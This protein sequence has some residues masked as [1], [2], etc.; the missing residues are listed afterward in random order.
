MTILFSFLPIYLINV[1]ALD[2]VTAGSI[3]GLIF[4]PWYLK[5]VYGGISDRLPIGRFGRRRPYI[6]F[7]V[8]LGLLGW[9]F[10]PLI[11]NINIIF[12]SVGLLT[13][14]STACADANID[15]L[16]IDV[17]PINERGFLQGMMWGCRGLGASFSGYVSGVIIANYGWHMLF[18]MAGILSV[19][20]ILSTFF[21]LEPSGSPI[22]HSLSSLKGLIKQ[23]NLWLG[24]I[25]FPLVNIGTGLCFVF[26]SPF[27]VNE[28]MLPIDRVGLC[29][30]LF[31][32][33]SIFSPFIAGKMSDSIGSLK[34]TCIFSVLW[35]V[36]MVLMLTIRPG[37]I[38]W[39]TV[40]SL[41]VGGAWGA[42]ITILLRIAMDISHPEF[43]G[44]MFA[45]FTSLMNFGALWIGASLGGLII[46]SWGYYA[47]FLV[48][49]VFPLAALIFMYLMKS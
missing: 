39:P 5:F 15:G 20:M 13:V 24:V 9:Y 4:L 40:Y 41:L 44:L 45:V 42:L 47:L 27:L 38:L 16:A 36:A 11:S 6:F 43:A 46:I 37:A 17:T 25:Y 1:F 19:V 8:C 14:F 12:I 10:A 49:G 22:K 34:T 31:Y 18:W 32:A 29:I 30:S 3:Y 35:A 33:G 26:F 23:K 28:I 7:S 2:P 21:I 48:S